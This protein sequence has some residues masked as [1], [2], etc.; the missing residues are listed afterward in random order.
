MTDRALELLAAIVDSEEAS[1]NHWTDCPT[2]GPV[3][4]CAVGRALM[5]DNIEA[6]LAAKVY[7]DRVR[8][9]VFIPV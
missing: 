3:P 9:G 5:A 8:R 7:L 2:C 1:M 6:T 4:K